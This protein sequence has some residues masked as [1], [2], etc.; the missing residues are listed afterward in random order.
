MAAVMASAVPQATVQVPRPVSEVAL[1]SGN[2]TAAAP[3]PAA[4]PAASDHDG[5]DQPHQHRPPAPT[6][7][8][9]GNHNSGGSNSNGTPGHYT[10]RF[11]GVYWRVKAWCAQIQHGGRKVYLG[12][13]ERLVARR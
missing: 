2:C 3:V 9:G 1:T 13:H 11:R 12:T 8:A 10:S 5:H 4:A 6:A 7:A